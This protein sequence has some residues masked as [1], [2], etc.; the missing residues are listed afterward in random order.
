MK[1]QNRDD[2]VALKALVEAGTVTPVIEGTYPLSD[3][4]AAIARV[5]SGRARGTIVISVVAPRY[6]SSNDAAP[7]VAAR[8]AA[9]PQAV[10]S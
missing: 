5:A 9:V 8:D 3:T 4:A 2:L 6:T 7:Q 10:A 1:T